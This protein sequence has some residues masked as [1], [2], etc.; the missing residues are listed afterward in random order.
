[1]GDVLLRRARSG[2]GEVLGELGF[3][4]WAASSFAVHDAGRA[5]RARLRG[6]FASFA[7]EKPDTIL[8]AEIDGEPVG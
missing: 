1:M 2:E 3:A 6:E 4:S 5:D 7:D 8:V